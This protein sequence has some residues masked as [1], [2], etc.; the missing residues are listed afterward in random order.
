MVPI[1]LHPTLKL[2]HVALVTASGLLFALRGAAVQAGAAWAMRR[3]WRML[4]YVI[5]TLLLAAGATLWWL[6]GL[7]PVRDPWLGTKLAL[8]LLYIV[9]GSLAMKR[10]RTPAVRRASYGAALATYLFM[11]SVAVRHRPLGLLAGA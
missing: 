6:L 8:L 7:H 11:A 9:L 2:A 1:D 10:G 3:P 5:D 4:S